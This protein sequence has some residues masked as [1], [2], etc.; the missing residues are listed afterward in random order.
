M[1]C[2]VQRVSSASV[3]IDGDVTARIGQGLLVLLGIG[4]DDTEQEVDYLC[5]KV[6]QLRIFSDADDKM[7]LSL[8][9]VGGELL[10]VSQFTL[11]GDTRKGNRPSFVKAAKPPVAIPLY[12]YFLKSARDSGINVE[13]GVFGADMAV[14]L[15]NNG[16]VTIWIDTAE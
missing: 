11:F 3:T 15:V 4:E 9:D 6:L 10:V 1:R 2:L 12:E 16:P 8:K 5:R 14:Q 7:N 13:H